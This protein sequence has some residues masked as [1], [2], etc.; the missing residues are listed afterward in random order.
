[1]RILEEGKNKDLDKRNIQ[2]KYIRFRKKNYQI[3]TKTNKI[4]LKNQMNLT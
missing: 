1:M 4:N 3:F 2:D